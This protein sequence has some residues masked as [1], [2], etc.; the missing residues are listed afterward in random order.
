MNAVTKTCCPARAKGNDAEAGTALSSTQTHLMV[1]DVMS[2]DVVTTTP[3]ESILA[4][5]RKMAAHTVSCVVVVD[6][7]AVVGLFTEKDLLKGISQE[8]AGFCQ[9]PVAERMSSPVIVAAPSLAVLDAGRIL[10][11]KHIKH[12]PVVADQR[13]VGIVTQTD[14]TRGL[15]YLTP[16]QCVSE[17]MSPNVATV[18]AEATIEEAAATMWTRRISCVLVTHQKEPVGILTQ[19]DILRRIVAPQW[20]PARTRVREVM[21]APVLPIPPDYSVFTASRIMDKMHVHRLVVQGGK[22]IYGIVSQT[23]ILRALERRLQEE[24]KR[25]QFLA[26]SEIPLFT[27][28]AKGRVTY[29]N[30][31]FLHMLGREGDEVVGELLLNGDF[32]SRP[33]DEKRLSQMLEK[34]RPGLLRPVVRTGAGAGRRI[35]LLLAVMKSHAG[36]VVGWQGVAWR[37]N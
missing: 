11:S 22:R 13:L 16:L 36:E 26:G 21:S 8:R 3:Q 23:D 28:D 15:I 6:G 17:I 7:A 2:R 9:F 14:I 1:K 12:L 18:D 20:N 19:T 31:A 30:T 10:K 34:G 5:A 25:R 33:Q 35:L 4:A 27:L 29:A 24:E 37:Q 32:W